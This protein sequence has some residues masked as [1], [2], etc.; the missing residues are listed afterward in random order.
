VAE[1]PAAVSAA[2][3]STLA[4]R[5]GAARDRLCELHHSNEERRQGRSQRLSKRGPGHLFVVVLE[6]NGALE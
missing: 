2:R 1:K 5:Q 3:S 6:A 4:F